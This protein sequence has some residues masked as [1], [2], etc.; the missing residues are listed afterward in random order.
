MS[1]DRTAIAVEAAI[2]EAGEQLRR[3]RESGNL[4][5]PAR[6]PFDFPQD[7]RTAWDLGLDF[8]ES[9]GDGVGDKVVGVSMAEF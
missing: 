4:P 1:N 7:E 3:S 8:R 6:S 5:W 2:Q 9:G